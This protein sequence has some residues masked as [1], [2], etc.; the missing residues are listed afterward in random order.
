[1]K[2][3]SFTHKK[4]GKV[5]GC[6]FKLAPNGQYFGWITVY[7]NETEYQHPTH[8][9]DYKNIPLDIEINKSKEMLITFAEGK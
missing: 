8:W 1:M 6:S 3:Q 9:T 7:D 4:D 2:R 5:F